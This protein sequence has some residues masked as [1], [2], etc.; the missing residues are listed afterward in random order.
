M[1]PTSIVD[2]IRAARE[3]FHRLVDEAT[4]A[5]LRQRSN[6]TKWTND[7]LLFHMLFG[8]LLVRALVWLVRGFSRLPP[9]YSR[10]FAHALDT[11]SRPFHVV[12]YLG[13]LG[14]ARVLGH[15]GMERVMDRVA[16]S[17][18]NTLEHSTEQQ[19]A[20]GMHFPVDW[21]PYFR[22]YMTVQDVLHYATQHY[23]HH[24]RQLTLS[25]AHNN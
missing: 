4:T 12:N 7:Q 16:T 6:G 24:R 23:Q 10:R 19:L 8:Y 17:L 14:G 3:D 21:D 13:S 20:R 18:T 1:T 15:G 2:D 25:N 9:D 5:D 11:A 22:D